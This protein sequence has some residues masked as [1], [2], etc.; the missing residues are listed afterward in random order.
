MISKRFLLSIRTT[1]T[2]VFFP[3]FATCLINLSFLIALTKLQFN[4]CMFYDALLC[5][6]AA[7][8]SFIRI[9]SEYLLSTLSFP[10]AP[11]YIVNTLFSY[12]PI[13]YC[14]FSVFLQTHSIFILNMTEQISTSYQNLTQICLS[15]YYNFY[16]LT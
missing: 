9:L 5:N 1:R 12:S 13:L 16:V 11:F 6:F 7:S 10:T 4:K 8:H 15:A 2:P 14:Q 3:M